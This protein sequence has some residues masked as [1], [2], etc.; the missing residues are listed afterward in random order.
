MATKS[1]TQLDNLINKILKKNK[2]ATLG[3]KSLE[4]LFKT[5]EIL[6]FEKDQKLFE[7]GDPT[8]SVFIT[9]TGSFSVFIENDINQKKLA[10]IGVGEFIG[11]MGVISGTS[12]SATVIA[13]RKSKVIELKLKNIKNS[14]VDEFE[15]LL[16]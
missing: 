2:D 8:L 11:E 16:L 10:D 7:Q 6:S 12:R 3:K 1:N 9:I 5:G 4:S 13:N 14:S 15:F